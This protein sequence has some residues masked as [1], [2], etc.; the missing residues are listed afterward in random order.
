M[1]GTGETCN[2]IGEKILKKLREEKPSDR[3]S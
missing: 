3:R 2:A 1:D